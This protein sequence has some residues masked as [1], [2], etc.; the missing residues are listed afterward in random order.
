MIV[1]LPVFY[2]VL[3]IVQDRNRPATTWLQQLTGGA[4]LSPDG[5]RHLA[6]AM[7]WGMLAG[8]LLALTFTAGH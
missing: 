8:G 4:P 7:L 2:H 1:M 3:M 5:W 6:K